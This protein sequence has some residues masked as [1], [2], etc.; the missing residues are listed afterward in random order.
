MKEL[1]T[2][3][4]GSLAAWIASTGINPEAYLSLMEMEKEEKWDDKFKPHLTS[5]TAS[6]KSGGRPE[7]ADVTNENTEK[8]KTNNSNE[9]PRLE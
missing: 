3:G 1:Y 5:F 2:L 6:T 9:V 7:K 4:R 8:S